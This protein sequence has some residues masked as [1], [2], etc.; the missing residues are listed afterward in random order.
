MNRLSYKFGL[1]FIFTA[2]TLVSSIFVFKHNALAQLTNSDVSVEI[3]P[4]APGPFE[5]VTVSLSSFAVDLNKATIQWLVNG[6]RKPGG[7]GIKSVSFSTGDIGTKTTINIVIFTSSVNKIEKTV[8]VEPNQI[9]LLWEATDS[10]VPPFYEGKALPASESLIKV[11][12]FPNGGSKTI[13]PET[14]VYSWKR[15]FVS[16]QQESGYGKYYYEFRT[17]YFNQGENVSLEASSVNQGYRSVGQLRLTTTKP[18]I[19]FYEEKPLEGVVYQNALNEGFSIKG[20]EAT[21]VSEPYFYSVN[22]DPLSND[23]LYAWSINNKPISAPVKKNTL[24]LRTGGQTGRAKV[25]LSIE[26]IP[27]LFQVVKQT[28]F[29]DITQ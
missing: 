3:S 29:V 2:I 24:I 1:F 19:V 28:F 8:I 22:M 10:Y 15:N 20:G 5:N 18:K 11:V 25:D 7:T 21:I 13:K 26:S 6:Q 9:D 14:L 17:S 23:L 27:R 12:A 16:A 4:E